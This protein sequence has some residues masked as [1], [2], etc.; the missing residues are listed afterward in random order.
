MH[1]HRGPLFHIL[2]GVSTLAVLTAYGMYL[3]WG[4]DSGNWWWTLP[5]GLSATAWVAYLVWTPEDTEGAK[6][7]WTQVKGWFGR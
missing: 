1:E 5:L 2:V 4:F 6:D 7:V 3:R